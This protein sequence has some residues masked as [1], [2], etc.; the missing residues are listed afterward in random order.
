VELAPGQAVRL[1]AYARAG[2][3]REHC[4]WD[5]CALA[6]SQGV[7]SQVTVNQ[8]VLKTLSD[9]TRNTIVRRCPGQVFD[10]HV[11]VV[12]AKRC[13]QCQS[14][15]QIASQDKTRLVDIEEVDGQFDVSVESNMSFTAKEIILFAVESIEQVSRDIQQKI[16]TE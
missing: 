13:T 9:E 12:H 7:V 14:C 15:N 3:G 2:I 16:D 6:D 5:P 4:R 11:K 8:D 10:K 1:E